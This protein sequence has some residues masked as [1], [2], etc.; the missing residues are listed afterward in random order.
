LEDISSRLAEQLGL[1]GLAN[2][3]LAERL[4]G[5][6]VALSQQPSLVVVDNLET[7]EEFAQLVPNLARL[8]GTSRFLITT[9]QSLR[10]FP[11]L[12]TIAV[13]ELDKTGAANLLQNEI[14][15]RGGQRQLSD[16]QFDALYQVI[17]GLPLVIKLVAAQLNLRPLQE[18]LDGF[19]N[20]AAGRDALYRYVYWQTWNSLHDPARRLLLSFLPA[21]AEG[22][23]ID[24][25]RLMSGQS[26]EVFFEALQELDQFSLLEINGEPDRPLYRLHRLTVTFLQTDILRLWSGTLSD[27]TP[28]D[29]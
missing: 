10:R 13:R 18:I 5:L 28:A 15:R 7:A 23:D 26:D 2:K 17:G 21:D 11:Y 19:R 14:K 9:R 12:T 24:F 20:V 4:E 22:E 25:L 8:A 27:D 16:E 1:S 3:P 29:Q 6:D